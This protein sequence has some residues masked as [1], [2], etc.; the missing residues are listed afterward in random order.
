MSSLEFK[1]SQK[2]L[3]ISHAIVYS[4]VLMQLKSTCGR[5]ACFLASPLNVQSIVLQTGSTVSLF[6][7]FGQS[8][9]SF[10]LKCAGN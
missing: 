5:V 2:L 9:A 6:A 7:L 1:F 8:Q 10:I 4:L 3:I